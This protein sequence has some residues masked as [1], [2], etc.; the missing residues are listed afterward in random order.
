MLLEVL[1][2]S[3]RLR[4]KGDILVKNRKL[5]ILIVLALF[6]IL[7]S[8]SIY[9]KQTATL[10][11]QYAYINTNKLVQTYKQSVE[12]QQLYQ[13]T[14]KEFQEFGRSLQEQTK[15]A[16]SALEKEKEKQKQG[17]SAAEKRL[18]DEEYEKKLQN[19]YGEKQVELNNKKTKL[20][21]RLE[22]N[23]LVKIKEATAKVAQEEE[24]PL[25]V[26]EG[27]IY[28][29]GIDLTE[30]VLTVLKNGGVQGNE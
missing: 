29:G 24:V 23:L 27:A 26:E 9:L 20:Y 14:E 2:N 13:K 22:Q 28:Y 15:K 3:L 4:N 8:I 6:L 25:V 1:C 7:V 12:F 19:L 10:Q 30:Q 21:A 17:K 11:C 5:V 18:L 16:V